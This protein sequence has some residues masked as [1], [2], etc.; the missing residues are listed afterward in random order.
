MNS[1]LY[2]KEPGTAAVLKSR[3]AVDIERGKKSMLILKIFSV[4]LHL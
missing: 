1:L 3:V 2:S 4:F